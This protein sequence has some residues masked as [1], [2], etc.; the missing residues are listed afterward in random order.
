MAS[1][2][3]ELIN[4]QYELHLQLIYTNCEID[5]LDKTINSSRNILKQLQD[6]LRQLEENLDCP[7][8][9]KQ[10]IQHASE[11]LIK[12]NQSQF[13]LYSS[14]ASMDLKRIDLLKQINEAK[15]AYGKQRIQQ[16][17]EFKEKYP[18]LISSKQDQ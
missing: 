17:Q 8:E 7:D 15:V 5:V 16:Q 11:Q 10:K 1:A 2:L 3:L 9:L 4:Q 13:K 6:Q 14:I 12:A 18:Q